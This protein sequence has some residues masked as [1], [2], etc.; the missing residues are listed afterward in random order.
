M[1]KVSI[2]LLACVMLVGCH[3]AKPTSVSEVVSDSLSI[4][5]E[6]ASSLCY[7]SVSIS[8]ESRTLVYD[9]VR[10]VEG[11]GS[12]SVSADGSLLL[13]G[14]AEV[15]S[16][17]LKSSVKRDEGKY[18]SHRYRSKDSV[19][20]IRHAESVSQQNTDSVS[21]WSGWKSKASIMALILLMLLILV[22]RIKRIIQTSKIYL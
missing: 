18:L 20:E 11:G 4:S 3:T 17:R 14:V 9:S 1:I 19:A 10:F 8:D 21:A 13:S 12:V 5:I 7:D 6:S 22:P 15:R 2:A 16:S